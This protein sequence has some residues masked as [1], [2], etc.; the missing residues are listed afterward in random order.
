MS[1]GHGD[2]GLFTKSFR[3]FCVPGEPDDLQW[4]LCSHTRGGP[5]ST[6]ASF[7]QGF[8]TLLVPSCSRD[9]RDARQGQHPGDPHPR[10]CHRKCSDT[11]GESQL[12]TPCTH[13]GA[14]LPHRT[15]TLPLSFLQAS[16]LT[17][18]V[19]IPALSGAWLLVAGAQKQFSEGMLNPHYTQTIHAHVTSQN[20]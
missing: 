16:N 20:C 2:S 6:R 14:C 19:H 13:P 1:G 5:R 12:R 15:V 4:G 18:H 11:E 3:E 17:L 10:N 8:Q 9:R 7:S